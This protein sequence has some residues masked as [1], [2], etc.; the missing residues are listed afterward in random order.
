MHTYAD[1]T[2]ADARIL[3][4]LARREY[5]DKAFRVCR[6]M[7]ECDYVDVQVMK[8]ATDAQYSGLL[9]AERICLCDGM[10]Y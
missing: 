1:L 8:F 10:F 6:A 3:A 9:P 4:M 2:A 7:Q 5:S